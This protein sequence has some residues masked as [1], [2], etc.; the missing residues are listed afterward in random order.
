MLAR[1]ERPLRFNRPTIDASLDA[2][3]V[4]APVDVQSIVDV[5]LSSL[6]LLLLW[7]E[8]E[9]AGGLARVGS[10][11]DALTLRSMRVELFALCNHASMGDRFILRLVN[12]A[13][14]PDAQ[15][16]I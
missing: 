13:S 11:A 15:V 3:A 1:A 4:G 8:R 7:R 5:W 14:V 6:V 16:D 9:Q 10:I 12:V 2:A